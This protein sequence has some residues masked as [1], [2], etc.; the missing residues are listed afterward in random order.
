MYPSNRNNNDYTGLYSS[1]DIQK[2]RIAEQMRYDRRQTETFPFLFYGSR[3][4]NNNYTL[5]GAAEEDCIIIC[6]WSASPVH[7]DGHLL[8]TSA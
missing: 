6:H 7:R 2:Y 5:N 3:A 4:G 1:Y 8:V